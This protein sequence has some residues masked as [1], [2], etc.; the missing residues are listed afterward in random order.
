MN[1]IIFLQAF[2][3]LIVGISFSECASKNYASKTEVL[4]DGNSQNKLAKKTSKAKAKKMTLIWSDEFDVAGAPNP[5]KWGND[6]GTG[7]WGWGNNEKE[8]Y[9][10][11]KE[12]VVIEKGIL[13]IKAIKE[14]YK[15]SAYTSAKLLTKEKFS[16]KYGKIEVRAKLSTGVGTWPAIWMLGNNISTAGWPACGEIDIMEHKGSEVN[17]IY[18]TL[19]YPTRFGDNGDGNTI[20]ILNAHTA[21]HVYSAEWSATEIKFYVDNVLFKTFVNTNTSPF[22]QNFYI[23]L[24]LAMG[25]N[26]AGPIDPAITNASMEVDYVRVY[27]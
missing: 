9:T 25:G 27:Q 6:I 11:R 14:D 17:K 13:K 8:Y 2:L 1:K 18:S 24:N 16:F 21:F 15:G 22:H 5:S 12:N 3:F 26:F 10:N 23:I 4:G 7:E 19:H 20:N